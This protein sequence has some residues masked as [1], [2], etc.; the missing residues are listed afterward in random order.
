MLKQLRRAF[1]T[2]TQGKFNIFSSFS[3]VKGLFNAPLRHFKRAS[4]PTGSNYSPQLNTTSDAFEEVAQEWQALV[5]GNPYDLNTFNYLEAVAQTNFGTVDNPHVVFTSDAPFRYVGCA[6]QPN[7]DDYEGHEY[8]V[9]MLREGPLQRCP[10][11]GQVFKLVRLRD[12]YTPEMDYYGSGILPYEVQEMNEFDT[13]V[14]LNPMKLATH[15]EYSQFESPSNYIYSMVNPDEHDRILTDPAYRMQKTLSSEQL[16]KIYVDSLVAIDEEYHKQH[17]VQSPYPMNRVDYTT[18]ID[19]EKAI[20]KIDRTLNKVSKFQARKLI[21]PANHERREKRM[22]ERNKAR[23]ENSMTFYYGELSE[24]EQKYRDY[25]ETDLEKYPENE[26]FEEK[27]DEKEILSRKEYRLENF[28][29]QEMYT[30]N[31]EDDQ[32][33]FVERKIF[34][35]KYRQAL[36]SAEV[37]EA[38]NERMIQAQIKRFSDLEFLKEWNGIRKTVSEDPANHEAAMKYIALLKKEAVQQYKDYFQD[39]KQQDFSFLEGLQG[40]DEAK[41]LT[42]FENHTTLEGDISGFVTMP[43]REWN[44]SLGFW[45]NFYLDLKEAFVDLRPQAQR[46]VQEVEELSQQNVIVNILEGSKAEKEK[47]IGETKKIEGKN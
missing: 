26:Q 10:S 19:V 47:K 46:I 28:D 1:S 24:E 9:F 31:P 20:K 25:Y 18:L 6:G 32:T 40:G 35:Y 14:L 38:R 33:T 42:I 22:M 3:A 21:D 13:P 17:G 41:F 29:F 4:Q 5:V 45:M 44:K 16:L 12:E 37:Y 7:E 15:H 43:K 23:W 34:Q 11:C 30:N 36:D 8:Q 2:S 27:L 39:D